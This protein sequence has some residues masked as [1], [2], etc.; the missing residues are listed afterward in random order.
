MENSSNAAVLTFSMNADI[1][2][3]MKTFTAREIHRNASAVLATAARDGI[4]R[5]KRRDGQSFTIQPESTS[6]KMRDLPD[7]AAR[8]RAIFPKPIPAAVARKLDKLIA[9]E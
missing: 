4:V 1:L 2:S 8:R 7:F 9:G 5:V 3:D 6:R